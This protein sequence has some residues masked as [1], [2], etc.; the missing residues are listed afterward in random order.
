MD[1]LIDATLEDRIHGIEADLRRMPEQLQHIHSTIQPA[2][3]SRMD[4]TGGGRARRKGE[5]GYAPLSTGAVDACDRVYAALAEWTLVW[6]QTQ[7]ITPPRIDAWMVRLPSEAEPHVEGLPG[8]ISSRGAFELTALLEA[9][10]RAQHLRMRHHVLFPEYL[11]AIEALR[12]VV[13]PWPLEHTLHRPRFRPCP[14]CAAWSVH[15]VV[16]QNEADNYAECRRCG[17]TFKEITP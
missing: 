14:L 15:A 2:S 5:L 16:L 6:A 4:P 17:H 7:S 9:F 13:K 10:L 12:E 11:D 3:A 1:A 8:G